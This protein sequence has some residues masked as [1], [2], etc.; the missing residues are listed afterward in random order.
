MAQRRPDLL[1]IVAP[2]R[3]AGRVYHRVL[4]G[5]AEDSLGGER[6]RSSL[7]ETLA[8][9]DDARWIVRPTPLAFDFG[10]FESAEAAE[11]RVAEIGNAGIGAYVFEVAGTRA[12]EF[13]VYAGAYQSPAEAEVMREALAAAFGSV[14]TLWPRMGRY[15]P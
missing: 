3:V 2:V 13:R 6:L 8:G 11:G 4:A 14:P 10:R 7:A 12:P 9:D 15:E 1:F 5:P